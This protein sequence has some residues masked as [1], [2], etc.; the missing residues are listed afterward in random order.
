MEDLI[1]RSLIISSVLSR[2][3]VKLMSLKSLR[4]IFTIS[5]SEYIRFLV[6]K[7]L[8]IF[9]IKIIKELSLTIEAIIELHHEL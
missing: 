6:S 8:R 3:Q 4:G 7:L 9:M 5:G 2:S 1:L